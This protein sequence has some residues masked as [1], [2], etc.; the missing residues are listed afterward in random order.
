VHHPASFQIALR[1]S[2]SW[3]FLNA[4]TSLFQDGFEALAERTRFL[5]Y[6]KSALIFWFFCIKTKDN[7]QQRKMNESKRGRLFNKKNIKKVVEQH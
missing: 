3:S 2:G 5:V 4:A 1:K 7:E 6:L